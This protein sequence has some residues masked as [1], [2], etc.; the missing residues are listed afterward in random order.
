MVQVSNSR[1]VGAAE[2]SRNLAKQAQ[3]QQKTGRL[4]NGFTVSLA[5]PAPT[6]AFDY[7][8]ADAVDDRY[9]IP[10]DQRRVTTEAAFKPMGARTIADIARRARISPQA[11]RR[12]ARPN[13]GGVAAGVRRQAA[14]KTQARN[15][16]AAGSDDE[17]S[18]DDDALL[19]PVQGDSGNGQESGKKLADEQ[20]DSQA[21]DQWLAELGE[22]NGLPQDAAQRLKQLRSGGD[23]REATTSYLGWQWE[24]AVLDKGNSDDDVI[25]MLT[26][27]VGG[28]PLN[29]DDFMA[30]LM[31]R[32]TRPKALKEMLADILENQ[33]VLPQDEN[34]LLAKLQAT[35]WQ[36]SKVMELMRLAQGIKPV[37]EWREQ[38]REELKEEI[39]EKTRTLIGSRGL[40]SVNGLP[41][42][43][44]SSNL[45]TFLRMHM[46]LLEEP[47]N[48]Q[49][50][51]Q[52][53][54]SSFPLDELLQTVDQIKKALADNLAAEIP[55]HE[56][57]RLHHL[58]K[59]MQE[60]HAL[61]SVI[62]IVEREIKQRL[63]KSVKAQPVHTLDTF[64]LVK[65]LV[66]IMA[67]GYTLASHFENL[68]KSLNVPDGVPTIVFLT[69]VTAALRKFPLRVYDDDT[70]N[71]GNGTAR[72]N[73]LTEAADEALDVCIER[74]DEVDFDDAGDPVAAVTAKMD[75]TPM[76][77]IQTPRPVTSK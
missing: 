53:L 58:M 19:R 64:L 9:S 55:S 15:A 62:G 68:A 31:E 13:T 1:V 33:S 2:V 38:R 45:D 43:S 77:A 32:Q 51:A 27:V 39:P 70:N 42:A 69:G 52:L 34:E 29:T 25:A 4:N 18:E 37:A 57:A 23:W 56:P 14:S 3:A 24:A 6:A 10:S 49:Q 67:S 54:L 59:H 36:P 12:E 8:A 66:D 21:R 30:M 40:A 20:H 71:L 73:E 35:G 50:T 41:A 26:P 65:G 46:R 7:A 63:E 72:R 28:E 17:F 44:Q 75:A 47:Q 11:M 16:E 48:F 74:T 60:M 61:S 22:R 76:K 5:P